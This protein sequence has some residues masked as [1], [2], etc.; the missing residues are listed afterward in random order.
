[1]IFLG[2]FHHRREGGLDT[3]GAQVRRGY[4]EEYMSVR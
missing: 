3:G 4:F 2:F 1:M